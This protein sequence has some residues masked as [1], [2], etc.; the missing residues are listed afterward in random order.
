MWWLLACST[1]VLDQTGSE[2]I[3]GS[4]NRL[5]VY[6]GQGSLAITAT[7]DVGA[8]FEWTTHYDYEA[9]DVTLTTD[10]A[11]GSAE[12]V[13]GCKSNFICALDLAIDVSP[14]TEVILDQLEGV[15][16]VDGLHGPLTL[17]LQTGDVQLNALSGD[18]VVG[19]ETGDITGS[20]LQSYNFRAGGVTGSH[21]L[22]FTTAPVG[23]AVNTQVGD[24]EMQVPTGSYVLD[25]VAA[26]GDVSVTAVTD[27]PM[28][29]AG[30][31]SYVQSGNIV[32]M[33]T[34]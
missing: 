21:S 29:P 12:L 23:L 32:L 3:E 33:G 11:A 9:P 34:E 25:L 22:A 24:V 15:V 7:Q 10:T 5:S 6:T 28:A 14:E 18:T 1:T 26:S 8:S 17:A 31:S 20:D 30:I 2:R 16:S 13:L 4:L 27:D 19:V